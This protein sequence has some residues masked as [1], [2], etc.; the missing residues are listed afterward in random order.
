M[1][2]L[3][4]PDALWRRWCWWRQE[5]RCA[6]DRHRF[7]TPRA[8]TLNTQVDWVKYY[9]VSHLGMIALC[10]H[11]GLFYQTQVRSWTPMET[12]SIPNMCA[13]CC[14]VHDPKISCP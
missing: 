6:R 9:A 13:K 2:V 1:N 11:C 10:R 7:G 4:I 12:M 14:L 8:A 3:D 5:R